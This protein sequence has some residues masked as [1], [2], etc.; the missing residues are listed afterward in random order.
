MTI[1][2]KLYPPKLLYFLSF[3]LCTQAIATELKGTYASTH[4]TLEEFEMEQSLDELLLLIQKRLVIMH[5]V[6]RTK[7]NQN[8]AIEDKM[9]EQQILMQLAKQAHQYGLDEKLVTRFFEAQIEAS[10]EIQKNDFILW[11]ENGVVK[12][13]K[14]FSL[15]DELRLYI[16]QLNHKM[17]VLL[18]KIYKKPTAITNKY[19]LD[20]PISTRNS[21]YIEPIS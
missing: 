5:E 2:S 16:D 6:A 10:K 7:W 8:L 17:L 14:V 12:F 19:I 18:G 15:K 1:F 3:L 21:D 13:E 20:Y 4:E 11:K 9:R